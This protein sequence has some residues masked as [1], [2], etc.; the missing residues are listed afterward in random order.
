MCGY[1][2]VNCGRCRGESK[3]L[4]P[5]GQCPRCGTQ[6]DLE[7]RRCSQCGIPLPL[8]AGVAAS[9]PST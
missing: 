7:A 6:N 3:P 8:P 9:Q 2:C 1:V 4:S 5:R